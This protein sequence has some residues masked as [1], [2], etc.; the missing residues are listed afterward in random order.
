MNDGDF[1]FEGGLMAV[2][3]KKYKI[4]QKNRSR[5][6]FTFARKMIHFEAFE[7]VTN[8]S[9]NRNLTSLLI[10]YKDVNFQIEFI[11]NFILRKL[12]HFCIWKDRSST[13]ILILYLNLNFRIKI[14][15][16]VV[17]AGLFFFA[18]YSCCKKN[19]KRNTV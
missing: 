7:T 1:V 15:S 14:D 6:T 5:E 19:P 18:H 11:K 9:I 3:S 10:I 2:H 13:K 4:F 12:I 17:S 8:R 16:F